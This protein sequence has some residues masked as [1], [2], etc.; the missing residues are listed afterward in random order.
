MEGMESDLNASRHQFIPSSAAKVAWPTHDA[1]ARH[2]RSRRGHRAHDQ[3]DG[4]LTDGAVTTGW[5]FGLHPGHDGDKGKTPGNVS[6]DGAHRDGA[7]M[8]ERLGQ[9]R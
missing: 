1:G 4:A 9:W 2:A 7:S 8:W 6:L 5:P 3:R